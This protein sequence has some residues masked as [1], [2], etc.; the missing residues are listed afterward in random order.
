MSRK[1]K[2]EEKVKWK[3]L[4]KNVGWF[5][6][7]LRVASGAALIAAAAGLAGEDDQKAQ[8]LSVMGGIFIVEGLLRWCSLRALFKRPTKRAFRR[9][10]P[11]ADEA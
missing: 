5:G 6:M 1:K 3:F 2:K 9:H 7:L 8:M 10:Y 11:E 4:W